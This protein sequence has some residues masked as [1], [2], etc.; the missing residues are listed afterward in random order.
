[1]S[2][3]NPESFNNLSRTM[4]QEEAIYYHGDDL[5]QNTVQIDNTI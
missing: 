5:I 1:M 2:H 4:T 3:L